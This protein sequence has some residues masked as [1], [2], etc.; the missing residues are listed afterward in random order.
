MTHMITDMTHLFMR[1]CES[2]TIMFHLLGPDT[3]S[4][5]MI[6]E[7][8]NIE[9]ESNLLSRSEKGMKSKPGTE[10]SSNSFDKFN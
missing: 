7:M 2:L 9:R 8:K 1:N 3:T 6:Y 4:K 10:E 5:G